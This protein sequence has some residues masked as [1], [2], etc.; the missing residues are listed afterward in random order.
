[1]EL[2][3]KIR[4]KLLPLK[5]PQLK[6]IKFEINEMNAEYSDIFLNSV[7]TVMG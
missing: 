5:Y 4:A 6:K 2:Y 7:G 3:H 1:M